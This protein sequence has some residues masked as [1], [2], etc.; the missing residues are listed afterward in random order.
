VGRAAADWSATITQS[1]RFSADW[2]LNRQHLWFLVL[3][4]GYVILA[5]YHNPHINPF[6][7][8]HELMNI[9]PLSN[10]C[11]RVRTVLYL[12]LYI[13]SLLNE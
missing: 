11:S 5:A 10:I 3:F 2:T 9:R 12:H 13:L 6:D 7:L 1:D 8:F 4:T